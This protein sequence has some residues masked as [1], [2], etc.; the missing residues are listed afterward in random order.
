MQKKIIVHLLLITI[1]L[2][3]GC[4]PAR[5]EQPASV[6]AVSTIFPV[7]DILAN[8]GGDNIHV[9]TLL[10]A[11]ASPH[12]YEPPVDQVRAISSAGLFVYVEAA[13]TTGPEAG[14]R[15]KIFPLDSELSASSTRGRT[16]S[17]RA[18]RD[19]IILSTWSRTDPH[20]WPDPILVRDII[21]L[22]AE[23]LICLL[24]EKEGEIRSNLSTYQD[25][26]TQLTR[27][28]APPQMLFHSVNYL[29]A[30][31]LEIFCPTLQPAGD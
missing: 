6:C 22:L 16:T 17:S 3:S 26:L 10:P 14:S 15:H 11:G 20:F 29:H 23:K 28:S 25:E 19:G 13:W 9:L 18:I 21:C 30:L 2:L 5:Y 24:P 4:S 1:L 31:G 12:T 8:L 7:G 27:R